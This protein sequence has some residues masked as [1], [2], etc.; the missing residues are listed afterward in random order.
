MKKKILFIF[1][2]LILIGAIVIGTICFKK[3]KNDALPIADITWVREAHDF[4][5]LKFGADGSFR[6]SCA[7]GNP[8]DNADICETYKYDAEKKIITLKC[9]EAEDEYIKLLDYTDDTLTLEFYDGIRE[10]T[11]EQ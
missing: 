9:Y 2:I 11:K 1:I 10:F 4:E 8:V 7:C 3:E 5:T 6:Y